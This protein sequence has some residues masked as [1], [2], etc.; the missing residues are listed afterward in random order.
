MRL[1]LLLAVLPLAFAAPIITPRAGQVI[2]GKYIIK[3]KNDALQAL[4]SEALDLLDDEPEHKWDFGGFKGFGAKISD[5]LV[6]KIAALPGVSA[7][8]G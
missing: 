6:E 1:S 8:Y 7:Y 4:V 5:D 2:P 3:L